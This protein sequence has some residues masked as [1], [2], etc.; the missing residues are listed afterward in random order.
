M[1][2][3]DGGGG[4]GNIYSKWWD[5]VPVGI[6]LILVTLTD[7]PARAL[8]PNNGDDRLTEILKLSLEAALSLVGHTT[9]NLSR[10]HSTP[11]HRYHRNTGITRPRKAFSFN[12]NIPI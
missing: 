10:D 2:L 12:S 8:L 5:F 1:V 9:T 4:E 6:S 7:T 3:S 11:S